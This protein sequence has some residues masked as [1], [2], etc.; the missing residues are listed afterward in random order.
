MALALRHAALISA[1]TLT[2]ALAPAPAQAARAEDTTAPVITSVGLTEGQRVR[3]GVL[4]TPEVSDDTAVTRLELSG[5]GFETVVRTEAPWRPYW[6]TPAGEADVPVT[7]TAFDAAGNSSAATVTVHVDNVAPRV[8]LRMPAHY[9]RNGIVPLTVQPWANADM[10]DV[11]YVYYYANGE[12][13]GVTGAA[14]WTVDWDTTA[15]SGLVE[16]WAYVYDAVGN[17]Q[18]TE[19]LVTVDKLAPTKVTVGYPATDGY[20]GQ[21]G[22]LSVD[23]TDDLSVWGSELVVGGQVIS[24]N[25]IASTGRLDLRWDTRLA[26]G[27]VPITIR[28]SDQAG[29]VTE[30]R[31]TVTV[32]NDRPVVTVG[33]SQGAYLR[34]RVTLTLTGYRDATA[35]SD[36]QGTLVNSRQYYGFDHAD[37]TRSVVAETTQVPDGR[38]TL[39]W[40]TTD[41]AGNTTV[42][43]RAV[44]VDNHA[45]AVSLTK[46]PKNRAKVT[47]KFTVTAK[48]SDPYGVAKVQLLVNGKVVAT[49]ATAAYSFTVN[50]KKYGKKFTVRVRAYD[51]A[52]NVR[53]GVTRTYRR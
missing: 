13:V 15:H 17:V 3:K 33:A 23:A 18:V 48:A 7:L 41:A 32:D 6:L 11:E 38:Y 9:V 19:T 5:P 14:P 47:K 24:R 29:N 12:F 26:N 35:L 25:D 51:R 50:P 20:I 53:Y 49:D 31:R 22:L 52:G 10:S 34:G 21:G 4:L 39:G 27:P 2:A 42:V 36:F 37:A 40:R 43:T 44:T 30:V 46:A 28:V 45:P 1:L 8:G 16:L